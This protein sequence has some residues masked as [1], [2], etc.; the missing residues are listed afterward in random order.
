M[1]SFPLSSYTPIVISLFS[2]AAIAFAASYLAKL[3]A[4]AWLTAR[5]PLLGTFAGL[6]PSQ[7]P[8]IAFGI[9]LPP[10]LQTALIAL[11]L[12]LVTVAAVRGKGGRAQQI[13]FGL[14]IGGALGNVADRLL[15]GHV[16][17]FFQVG[18]FPIF[19]VADSCITLGVIL[20][21]L[22]SFGIFKGRAAHEKAASG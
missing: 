22:E 5:V 19:N 21:L 9:R 20:L 10:V 11:A 3:A 6:L 7:N 1:S 8:G 18:R 16:T 12:V 13:G 17:D 15:D 4:D 2:V 14:I